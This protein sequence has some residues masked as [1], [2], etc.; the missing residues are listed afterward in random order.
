MNQDLK[1][2]IILKGLAHIGRAL[3]LALAP[4]T[5]PPGGPGSP[6]G[7]GGGR[8]APGRCPHCGKPHGVGGCPH[9]GKAHPAH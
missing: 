2:G 5:P 6:G 7:L 9:C 8:H 1:A 4:T 3:A